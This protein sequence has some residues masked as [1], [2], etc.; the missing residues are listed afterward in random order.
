MGRERQN[1]T[2]PCQLGCNPCKKICLAVGEDCYECPEELDEQGNPVKGCGCMTTT[3]PTNAPS[4]T[5]PSTTTQ[6]TK[7]D[8]VPAGRQDPLGRYLK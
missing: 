4:T 3:V 2:H 7:T 1:G 8:P 6:N 5:V